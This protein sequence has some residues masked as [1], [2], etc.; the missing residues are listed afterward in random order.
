MPAM[1]VEE[2]RHRPPEAYQTYVHEKNG[3]SKPFQFSKLVD[4]LSSTKNLNR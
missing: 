1:F 3:F 4:E 2:H